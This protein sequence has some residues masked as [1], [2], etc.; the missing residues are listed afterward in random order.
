MAA[1]LPGPANRGEGARAGEVSLVDESRG[2]AIRRRSS[3]RSAARAGRQADRG[4]DQAD[5]VSGQASD[6]VDEVGGFVPR[7]VGDRALR[8]ILRLAAASL[9]VLVAAIVV[10]MVTTAMPA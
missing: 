2:P 9:V 3:L 4:E 6:G 7:N 5:Y 10:E 1:R 8:A